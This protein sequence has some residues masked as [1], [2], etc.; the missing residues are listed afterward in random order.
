ME[1]LFDI[2]S[3]VLSSIALAI[4][5]WTVTERVWSGELLVTLEKNTIRGRRVQKILGF[6]LLPVSIGMI[7]FSMITSKGDSLSLSVDI[8]Y[9]M[10]FLLLGLTNIIRKDGTSEIRE[11]GLF[12]YNSFYRYSKLDSYTW[13]EGNVLRVYYKNIFRQDDY[14]EV[15]IKDRDTV[16][17]A[18]EVLQKYVKKRIQAIS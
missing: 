11:K 2:L 9:S 10:F 1:R 4:V 17:K 15:E 14:V 13:L 8:I 12:I 7:I 6:I 3:I 5:I 18:D 16:S